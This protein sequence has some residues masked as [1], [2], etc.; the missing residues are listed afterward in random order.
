MALLTLDIGG[1]AVKYAVWKKQ[2][3]F[4]QG[5]F[6]TP[7]T[8]QPF[9]DKVKEIK[10]Q[11]STSYDLQGLA[12]S[13][14]GEIDEEKGSVGGISF[15]PFLHM[16]P[17]QDTLSQAVGL[18]VSLYNDANSAALA[19][20]KLG[21][22][23]KA[24]HPVFVIVGS[25]IG[26]ALVKD[27]KVVL[28]TAN[29]LEQVDKIITDFTRSIIGITASPVQTAKI[30]ALKKFKL[31]SSIDGKE[32]FELAE[33][34]DQVA[35]DQLDTMF[36]SLAEIL[37]VVNRSLSPEFIGIGGGITNNPVFIPSLKKSLSELLNE[38]SSLLSW[39]KEG[40]LE[41]KDDDNVLL[42]IKTCK[43]KNDANLI[44]AALH[45]EEKYK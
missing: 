29:E 38:D 26:L 24:D 23:K 6:P 18:K 20:M 3:L 19:E 36:R 8:R 2:K 11:L 25:G 31:P 41:N 34:G 30:V 5:D 35:S 21:I 42:K 39:I 44:G 17:I 9:F 4:E 16:V 12:V 10:E 22:G 14:P 27:G 40:A 32:V 33:N 13:C 37:L 28:D 43:F 15:V 1:S 45:F 7:A